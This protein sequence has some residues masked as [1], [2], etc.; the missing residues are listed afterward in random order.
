MQRIARIFQLVGNSR[1]PDGPHLVHPQA[2]V[3]PRATGY[4]PGSFGHPAQRRQIFSSFGIDSS[5]TNAK[6]GHSGID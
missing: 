1:E 5:S 6:P 2:T 4:Q 3:A